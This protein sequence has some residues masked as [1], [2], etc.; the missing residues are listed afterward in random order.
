MFLKVMSISV[1]NKPAGLFII[2]FKAMLGWLCSELFSELMSSE[3][4]QRFLD[5]EFK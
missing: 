1:L 4:L 2:I 3:A 5:E